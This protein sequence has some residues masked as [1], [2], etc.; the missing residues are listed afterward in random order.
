MKSQEATHG[1]A[2]IHISKLRVSDNLGLPIDNRKVLL[3]AEDI[4]TRPDIS[5]LILTVVPDDTDSFNIEEADKF[6][7]EVVHGRHRSFVS[8]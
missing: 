5:Q 2:D 8:Y 4:A 6:T 3:L 1:R 7:Y